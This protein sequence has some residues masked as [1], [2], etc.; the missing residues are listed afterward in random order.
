MLAIA[1]PI[2]RSF[3]EGGD[4]AISKILSPLAGESESEEALT[5]PCHSGSV[6]IPHTLEDAEESGGVGFLNLK[7]YI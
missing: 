1:S 2:R 4:E 6:G 3:S 7:S 5:S